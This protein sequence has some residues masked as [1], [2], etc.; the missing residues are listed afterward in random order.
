MNIRPPTPETKRVTAR[1]TG[2]VL[3]CSFIWHLKFNIYLSLDLLLQ[4][5]HSLIE[6]HLIYAIPVWLSTFQTYFN[7]SISYQNKDI[8][9]ISQAKWNDSLSP[10]SVNVGEVQLVRI[11]QRE[12]AEIIHRIDTIKHLPS[13]GKYNMFK[14]LVFHILTQRVQL[15]PLKCIFLKKTTEKKPPNY[16]NLSSTKAS[17][18]GALCPPRKNIILS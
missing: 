6:C 8:K 17:K 3:F 1:P 4:F 12:V 14:S 2:Q 10:L 9:I 16:K 5:Y 18:F 15:P 7:K 11:Y 13:L